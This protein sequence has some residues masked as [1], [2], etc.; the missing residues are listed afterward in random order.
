MNFS[1]ITINLNNRDG[2]QK[3]IDS[4]VPQTFRDFEWIV[5]DGGSTDGSKELI[6][7]NADHF[8]YWVS[9]P[10]KGI[11]NAMN[12]GIKVAKGEYLLFLNSGDW[13]A[14]DSVLQEV[15]DANPCADFVYGDFIDTDGTIGVSPEHLTFQR[16]YRSTICHQVVFHR[17]RLFVEHQ[18]DE[19]Y[20]I[21]SDW[22]FIF[23]EI[24]RNKATYQKMDVI[25]CKVQGTTSYDAS[26][27]STE[28]AVIL[29]MIYS[30]VE[31]EAIEDYLR[32]IESNRYPSL[33]FLEKHKVFARWIFR[34]I[35]FYM[36]FYK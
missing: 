7:R 28:R 16:L 5:I 2:L 23:E 14:S 30:E 35:R 6:E 31:R 9:E 11:Y 33:L 3:T 17:R 25:I 27:I 13:L 10:D 19:H 20:R 26:P 22:K 29:K 12:K 21:V 36:S 4:V 18:Y 1:I 15:F 32:I 8:S 34:V 24:A